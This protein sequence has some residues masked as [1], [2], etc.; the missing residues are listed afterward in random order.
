MDAFPER[1]PDPSLTVL[2]ADA[3]DHTDLIPMFLLRYDRANTKRSYARDLSAFFGTD[4]V[5]LELARQA[6]FTHVNAHL[7]ELDAA[8]RAPATMKRR[9]ASLRGFFAWLV[10]LGLLTLNPADRHLV[11]R[12]RSQADGDG[13]RH[14]PN[15][16]TGSG[17]RRICRH[18]L[19][20]LVS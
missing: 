2:G 8:G 3:T 10:S 18:E 6:T 11:R 14:D 15:G 4:V 20:F 1:S 9:L 19:G 17:S 13:V 5:T 16:R 7:A 12:I